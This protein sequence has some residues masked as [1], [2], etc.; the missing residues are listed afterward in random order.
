MSKEHSLR[1]ITTIVKDPKPYG[2]GIKANYAEA[3]TS[4]RKYVGQNRQHFPEY[5]G[6]VFV[7]ITGTPEELELL[8]AEL[9]R[10]G[11][12]DNRGES[13]SLLSLLKEHFDPKYHPEMR[14]MAKEELK[15]KPTSHKLFSSMKRSLRVREGMAIPAIEY[16]EGLGY[17]RATKEDPLK[18]VQKP[19]E[20]D[21]F[22]LTLRAITRDK[23][24]GIVPYNFWVYHSDML[25]TTTIGEP[26]RRAFTRAS[27]ERIFQR[28]LA[29]KNI[30]DPRISQT[31]TPITQSS[32]PTNQTLEEMT[33]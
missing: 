29:E 15:S 5:G 7:K 18:R 6:E 33:E 32:T 13:I 14:R 19:Q 23:A 11:F 2:L 21:D 30:P 22:C 24:Y 8:Q 1:S 9:K 27:V 20:E 12:S 3:V 25:F 26:A 17:K 4:L 28:Y 16:F 31:P 10:L